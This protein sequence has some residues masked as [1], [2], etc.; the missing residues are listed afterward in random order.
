MISGPIHQMQVC[1]SQSR[2]QVLKCF[3]PPL[4]STSN[5]LSFTCLFPS[6]ITSHSK[7]DSI[8]IMQVKPSTAS[9]PP[10]LWLPC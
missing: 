10:A 5:T 7:W 9:L 8:S 4:Y 6:I 1:S 3:L 2:K